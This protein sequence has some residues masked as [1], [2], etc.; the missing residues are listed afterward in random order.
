VVEPNTGGLHSETLFL[1]K[2]NKNDRRDGSA[3]ERL[4][5][6]DLYTCDLAHKHTI[7]VVIK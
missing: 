3:D 1:K 2:Q 7:S 5:P 6:N 4:P